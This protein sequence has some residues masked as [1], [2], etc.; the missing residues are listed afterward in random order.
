VAERGKEKEIQI[1]DGGCM[2]IEKREGM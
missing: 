2:E 1:V